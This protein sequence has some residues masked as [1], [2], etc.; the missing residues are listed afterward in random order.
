MRTVN[1]RRTRVLDMTQ[2]PPLPLLIQFGIPLLIGNIF[3]QVYGLVDTMVAGY[4][5]GDNAIASIG[6]TAVLFNLLLSVANGLNNGYAIIVT[7]R[8]G[9][10]DEKSLRVCVAG[11]MELNLL[12][13]VLLT[14]LSL[15]FLRPL[16]HFMQIP[17]A[18]FADTYGYIAVIF[19]GL[20]ATVTYNMFA[21]I[22]R[23]FGNSIT[24]LLFLIFSSCLNILLDFLFIVGLH[25]GVK[26][27]ALA[28]VLA[29]L[30]S[31][32]LSGAYVLRSYRSFLPAREDWR[33]PRHVLTDLLSQGFGMAIMLCV[34]NLGTVIYFR[35]NNALGE[36]F[37]TAQS[38][39]RRIV[40]LTMMP[41][42]T[43][44]TATATFTGQNW[45]ADRKDRIRQG[46]RVT[47]ALELA[48]SVISIGIVFSFGA[49]LEGLITGSMNAEI[50]QGAVTYMRWHVSFYPVL[51][52]L[53][54]LR[55]C[56]QSMGI[57]LAPI[58]SSCV[59]LGLKAFS[60]FFIIPVVGFIG[61]C[62]T[63]PLTWV[64]MQ[65]YLGFAYFRMR[66]K[67]YGMP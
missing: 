45:G 41:M 21:A 44:A 40:D 63:E 48:W 46:M 5:L 59:E 54:A 11:M 42:W 58:L 39:A 20:G 29:Q 52:L 49:R 12:S 8:F 28:T 31:A 35:A 67:L 6:A 60:A 27:A 62:M 2:G 57:K 56:M 37:I 23:A 19:A 66:K 61:I 55:L 7:Q 14:G 25:Y 65:L 4:N 13:S 1:G 53:L 38:S 33:V 16:L 47:A 10:H 3:Q 36:S 26:G 17:E 9:A 18:I 24:S 50:L 22:M 15:A 30:I 43:L 64:V 51:G 34:V 32:L